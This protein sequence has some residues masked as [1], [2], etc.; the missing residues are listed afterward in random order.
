PSLP[1][2]PPL[3]APSPGLVQTRPAASSPSTSPPVPSAERPRSPSTTP[4]TQAAGPSTSA[5]S[6]NSNGPLHWPELPRENRSWRVV[7]DP[8]VEGRAGHSSTGASN[9]TAAR[10]GSKDLVF[11]RDGRDDT[12]RTDD[13]PATGTHLGICWVK[14]ASG[15]PGQNGHSEVGS[16][17][18]GANGTLGNGGDDCLRVVAA[19]QA[20]RQAA[21]DPIKG[22]GMNVGVG[23]EA[24][25]VEVV[26]DPE[27]KGYKQAVKTE[28]ARRRARSAWS[29]PRPDAEAPPHKH[30]NGSG[31]NS[32][33]LPTNDTSHQSL[34]PSDGRLFRA[35]SEV[36]QREKE[37]EAR[38]G[39]K[40]EKTQKRRRTEASDLPSNSQSRPSL[41]GKDAT[42]T[43]DS[44][45]KQP[46]T[47]INGFHN[48][49]SFASPSQSP[50][51]SVPSVPVNG[52]EVVK[53][54][55][56]TSSSKLKTK[57]RA[58]RKRT[59][60]EEGTADGPPKKKART[61]GKNSRS[62]PV[63]PTI[64]VDK[65][66][67]D[68]IAADGDAELAIDDE[69][70]FFLKIGL[71]ARRGDHSIPYVRREVPP[72]PI[73]ANESQLRVHRT[74]ASRSEGYYKIPEALKSTYLPQRNRA[75]VLDEPNAVQATAEAAGLVPTATAAS[76]SSPSNPGDFSK[77]WSK[78][79]RLWAIHSQP[80]AV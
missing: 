65:D 16:S 47:R 36:T 44:L 30:T 61:S 19:Q 12:A 58:P 51:S 37:S 26:L 52:S 55:G 23:N 56:T 29:E 40:S 50:E 24:Q 73:E 35:T 75:M 77:A 62:R 80:A 69:E 39:G 48:A 66:V 57:P 22:T 74:G 68:V 6:S 8:L 54:K 78:R 60:K 27:G 42:S 46:H 64:D 25:F 9:G 32:A 38:A 21:R 43:P 13:D 18:G 59:L 76:A 11:L 34:L 1:P 3:S 10:P 72:P 31:S 67:M 49:E 33:I 17:S 41:V 20:V 63:I 79:T 2:L 4:T 70:L 14:F 28:L 53:T 45:P 7:Y 15:L 5:S 71:A